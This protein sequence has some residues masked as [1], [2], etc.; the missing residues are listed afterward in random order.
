MSENQAINQARKLALSDDDINTVLMS[1]TKQLPLEIKNPYIGGRYGNCPVC[2]KIVTIGENYC[3][4][5]GQRLLFKKQP[6]PGSE[7]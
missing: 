2:S 7:V 5:C 4:E 6:L 1:I 3:S